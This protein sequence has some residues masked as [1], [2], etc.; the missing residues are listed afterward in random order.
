M[1]KLVQAF[2]SCMFIS[3]LLDFFLFLGIFQNYIRVHEIDLYYNILF[4]DNQSLVLFLLFSIFLGYIFLYLSTKI[5]LVT[6]GV[7]ALLSLSTLIT[8][9]GN[10]V[11]KV[12]LMKKDV[13]LNIQ[14]YSYQGDILYDGREYITFYDY[15]FKKVLELE[16]NKIIGEY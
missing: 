7:L 8:P 10:S 16:K 11:A 3:F 14:K 2:L 1:S 9:I 5:V 4:A 12:I 13:V 15:R 6:I